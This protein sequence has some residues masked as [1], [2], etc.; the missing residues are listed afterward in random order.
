MSKELI[1]SN[2]VD[3]A[4]WS[5]TS[6]TVSPMNFSLENPLVDIND[7][8]AYDMLVD[9]RAAASGLRVSEK[10][11]LMHPA[12]WQGLELISGDLAAIPI[13]PKQKLGD[14]DQVTLDQSDPLYGLVHWEANTEQTAFEFWKQMMV[15]RL[16][17]NNAYAYIMRNSDGTPRELVPLLPDRTRAER[18]NN[19][20]YYITQVEG[21][22]VELLASEV[23]HVHGMSLDHLMGF[24]WI[25][26]ARD[27]IGLALAEIKFASDFYKNGGR[28]GGILELPSNMPKKAKDNVE[29]GFRKSYGSQEAFKTVVLR[30]GAKFHAAQTTPEAAQVVEGRQESVRDIARYFNVRPGKLGD[31]TK[32]SFSSKSEDNRDHWDTTL[33]PHARSITQEA[34]RK[35]TTPDQKRQ[36]FYFAYDTRG[37]LSMSFD[38]LASSLN[39]LRASEI[40]NADE[41]RE[42]LGM[43]KREDGRGGEY[44]NTNINT[45]QQPQESEDNEAF[46]QLASSAI[47]RAA[48]LLRDR[49]VAKSKRNRGKGLC[50]WMDAGG[51]NEFSS[52]FTREI[53]EV[54]THVSA[55][56]PVSETV[57]AIIAD[58]SQLCETVL[59]S[60]GVDEITPVAEANFSEWS[61]SAGPRFI[62][63]LFGDVDDADS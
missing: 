62:D 37:L 7:P 4:S 60:T 30:E 55:E 27:A 11:S 54:T 52:I 26:A 46:R 42:M 48:R 49:V 63:Q 51:L 50:Q 19:Q 45:R 32:E 41:A 24:K 31:E 33:K 59:N 29:T 17:W 53:Q 36:G 43:N 6:I 5:T 10:T 3:A 39:T 57:D 28:V 56:L 13:E 8:D 34:R 1:H 35:L 47:S 16:L 25:K 21:E 14:G 9:G 58:A 23:F 20:G 2:V 44:I 40:V 22:A 38:R 61:S 15:D 12:V 18:R